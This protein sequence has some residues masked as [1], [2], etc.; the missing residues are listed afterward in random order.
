ML[1]TA[2]AYDTEK[3]LGRAYNEIVDRLTPEDDVVFLDHDACWTTRDWYLHLLEAIKRYPD[4]GLF[5]AMTN[6]V[7]NKEQIA[8][9]A[10]SGHDMAAHRAFGAAL[11]A[12]HGSDAIDVT[13]RHLLS[14]TVLCFP[15]PVLNDV[16]FQNGFFGVDNQVHRDVRS[17]GRKI[18]LLRGVYVQHWYR[19]NGEKH[20]DAPRAKPR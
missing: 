3:N 4:A 15:K 13:N 9:G 5:G 8:E 14:G 19:G 10:P 20:V 18:Y 2:I 6:R 16:R 7:G 17:A 12:K 1:V 11:W